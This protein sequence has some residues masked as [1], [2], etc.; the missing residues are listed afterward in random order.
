MKTKSEQ[1]VKSPDLAQATVTQLNLSSNNLG[2]GTTAEL[3]QAFAATPS[4]VR[5]LYTGENPNSVFHF[6]PSP[7][8]SGGNWY[9]LDGTDLYAL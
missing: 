8:P 7:K 5:R 3:A 4:S 9:D 1:T 6:G 2:N